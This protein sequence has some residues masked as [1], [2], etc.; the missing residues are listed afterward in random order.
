MDDFVPR[1]MAAEFDTKWGSW[2]D[3]VL[4]WIRLRAGQPNFILLRYE[5]MKQNPIRELERIAA[6]LERCSFRNVDARA[7]RL[8]RAVELSSPERMR[9][10]EKE[11]AGNWVLTRNTRSDKPF[12]RTATAGGWRSTLSPASVGA[13]ESGWGLIMSELGYELTGGARKEAKV[14]S[15]R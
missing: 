9:A 8:Q 15:P 1:F 14:Q 11:Q 4:S 10:L 3:H 12:V 5:D 2:L 7:E 13:I 6:F